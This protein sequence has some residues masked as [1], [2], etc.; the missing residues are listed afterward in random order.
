MIVDIRPAVILVPDAVSGA[1]RTNEKTGCRTAVKIEHYIVT[2]PSNLPSGFQTRAKIVAGLNDPIDG[3]KP[4]EYGRDPVFEEN[5]DFGMWQESFESDERRSSEN[6]IADRAKPNDEHAPDAAPIDLA[7]RHLLFYGRFLDQH[8][9]DVIADR[10]DELALRVLALERFLILARLHLGFTL[11]ATEDLEKF[12][13]KSHNKFCLEF[14][15]CRSKIVTQSNTSQEPAMKKIHLPALIVL[16]LSIGLSCRLMDRLSG[17]DQGFSRSNEL[18]SDVPRIDGLEPSEMELPLAIK[19]LMR[20]V[21]NNLWRLNN[22]KE[23]KT[24]T[25]GDWIVF[26]TTKAPA[27]VQAFYTNDRMT[28]FGSWEASKQSTCLDGKESGVDGILCAFEKIADGKDIKLAI[29]AMKDESTKKTNVF[30][31]RLEDD[32][33]PGA[34]NTSNVAKPSAERSRSGPIAPLGRP[35]P[36]GIDKKPMPSGT[37]LETLLPKRV[38]PYER[39]LLERSEQRGTVADKI[40]KAGPSVYAT[41]RDGGKEIFVEL[42][43]NAKAEDAQATLKTA[44]DEALGGI[45]SSPNAASIGTE[46]SFAT[47]VDL[48]PAFIA[49][50]RGEYFFSA[51]AKGGGADLAAFMNSFPF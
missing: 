49:W 45:P 34:V 6:R 9:R 40:E 1:A 25:Q 15:L 20:T 37:D 8:H 5:V 47:A 26:T 30:F 48:G 7:L 42:A 39:V 3:V 16:V 28:S 17:G 50:T 19:I 11:R 32:A 41:Y 44:A 27:D 21:L 35:A 14:S 46:P 33:K 12:R 38:G 22:E 29:I 10:I 43:L 13:T 4:V 23:D 24:P 36:Y 51:D 18:W 31:L 2:T